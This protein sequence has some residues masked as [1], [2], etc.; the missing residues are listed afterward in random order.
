MAFSTKHCL[1]AYLLIS[2]LEENGI[3]YLFVKPMQISFYFPIR[4]ILEFH[5]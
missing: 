3:S 1:A 5:I 2:L 4:D